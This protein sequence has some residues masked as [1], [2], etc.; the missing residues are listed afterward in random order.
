M[1]VKLVL[2]EAEGAGSQQKRPQVPTQ[3]GLTALI[4]ICHSERSEESIKKAHLCHCEEAVNG[5]RGNLKK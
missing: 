2:S 4:Q 5:R 1:P 3:S